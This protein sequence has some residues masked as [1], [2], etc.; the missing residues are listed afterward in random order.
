MNLRELLAG[1]DAL[2][3]S[4]PSM[5]LYRPGDYA[6][7]VQMALLTNG[8]KHWDVCQNAMSVA[9]CFLVRV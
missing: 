1:E 2:L 7:P 9:T 4:S 5:R 6:S 8:E 3:L